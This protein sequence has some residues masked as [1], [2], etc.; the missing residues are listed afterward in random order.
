MTTAQMTVETVGR[1]DVVKLPGHAR[2][3]LLDTLLTAV[4]RDCRDPRIRA[5][6]EELRRE[7]SDAREA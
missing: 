4:R 5:R 1:P 7:A 6:V 3:A 2:D